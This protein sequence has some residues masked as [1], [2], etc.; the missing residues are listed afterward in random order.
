MGVCVS[1]IGRA[2]ATSAC[3]PFV[4]HREPSLLLS[5]RAHEKGGA[6]PAPRAKQLLHRIDADAEAGLITRGG[7]AVQRTLL[8]C[9]VERGH[10]L[11]V[12]LLGGLLVAL[13]DGLAQ[14][15]QR[16]AQAGGVG[17]IGGRALRGLTGAFER[18]KMISH[19]WFVTFVCTERYSASTEFLIIGK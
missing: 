3:Q 6:R 13:L 18:R 1:K 2:G 10:R 16:G 17:A 7:I 15:A 9:L 14:S 4:S 5:Q 8:D 12:G 11:A 19:V